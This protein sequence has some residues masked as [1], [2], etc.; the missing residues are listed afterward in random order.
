[1]NTALNGRK[2]GIRKRIHDELGLN[3]DVV[4][5]HK[6]GVDRIVVGVHGGEEQ[7][8][9][10]LPLIGLQLSKF[11]L[12]TKKRLDRRKEQPRNHLEY[13]ISLSSDLTSN[14]VS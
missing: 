3:T 13:K 1:M 4:G 5:L 2:F 14:L 9:R 7:V 6:K 8:S 10:T 11:Q 12:I